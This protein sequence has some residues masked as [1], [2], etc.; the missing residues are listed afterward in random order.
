MYSFDYQRP[1][2]SDAAVAF[3]KQHDD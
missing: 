3:L 2:K 1:D